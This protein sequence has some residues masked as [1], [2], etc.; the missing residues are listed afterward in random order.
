[1]CDLALSNFDGATGPTGPTG[2]T[3]QQGH[4]GQQGLKGPQGFCDLRKFFTQPVGPRAFYDLS[5]V[6]DFRWSKLGQRLQNVRRWC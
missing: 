6:R 1:M 2:P 5:N 4:Q 3:G